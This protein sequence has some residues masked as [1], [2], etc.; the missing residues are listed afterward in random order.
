MVFLR[1]HQGYHLPG[2]PAKAYSQQ[3]AGPYRV[4]ERVSRL[5]Y[6]LDI[7]SNSRI[8]PVISIA[9][10][11]PS[12]DGED[13]FQRLTPPPGP[14]RDDQPRADD[15]Y[16]VEA[17]L[18]HCRDKRKGGLKYLLKWLGYGHEHNTWQHEGDLAGATELIGEY[19][20]RHRGADAQRRERG[21]GMTR[22]R[23]IQRETKD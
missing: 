16:E 20:E 14:V 2:R 17:I 15:E 21:L 6:R 12:A 19:W 4:L 13:P 7:P 10:L 18:K 3:R 1:L 8:H 5:A 11:S 23:G 9:H 22:R